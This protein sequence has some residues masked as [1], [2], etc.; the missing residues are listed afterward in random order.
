MT[1]QP[2]TPGAHELSDDAQRS[3]GA[4]V[5]A[6]PAVLLVL[7]AGTLGL[8]ASVVVY[9]LYKDKGAFVRRQAANSINV[10]ITTFVLLAISAL[11]MLVLIGF[12]LYPIVIVW[13]V[14]LH[15][16]GAKRSN[17]GEWWNPPLTPRFL[18]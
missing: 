18:H 14:V 16:V 15:V 5:H 6:I 7:S 12:V 13:A 17:D 9:V 8:V 4:L 3:T 2:H 1:D 11:L 10:Q